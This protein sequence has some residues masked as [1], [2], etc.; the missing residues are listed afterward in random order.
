MVKNSSLHWYTRVGWWLCWPGS[1]GWSF[2]GQAAW[3]QVSGSGVSAGAVG[4]ARCWE[5]SEGSRDA[6]ALGAGPCSGDFKVQVVHLPSSREKQGEAASERFLPLTQGN[7][8]PWHLCEYRGSKCPSERPLCCPVGLL[9]PPSSASKV[10]ILHI[11][12]DEYPREVSAHPGP[13]S[14]YLP[15]EDVSCP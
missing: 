15:G 2:S 3:P 6:A 5:G 14:D 11:W 12:L 13:G 7:M 1:K 10:F 4:L 9:F 8:S